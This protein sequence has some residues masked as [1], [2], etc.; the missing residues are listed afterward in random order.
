MIESGLTAW[1]AFDA[2]PYEL[3]VF[4]REHNYDPLEA[5]RM[6]QLG[7]S[8]EIILSLWQHHYNNVLRK[9]ELQLIE[10]NK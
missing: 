2:L 9:Y 3:R 10:A 7:Y 5:Y 1:K 6:L 8:T 4:I